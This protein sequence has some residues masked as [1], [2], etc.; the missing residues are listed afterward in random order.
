MGLDS[1]RG[2]TV[3]YPKCSTHTKPGRADLV[4]ETDDTVIGI[5]NK[6]FAPFQ[7]HQPECYL[8]HLKNTAESLAEL[9]GKEFT[10]ALI[11]LAP[12]QRKN[13]IIQHIEAKKLEDKVGF[14]SWQTLLDG[15]DS[16]SGTSTVD[17]FLIRELRDFVDEQIGNV[18]DLP[19]LLPH[20]QRQWAPR[21]TSWQRHFL[22]SFIWS[23]VH[24]FVKE[25][26]GRYRPGIANGYYGWDFYPSK[27]DTATE[28]WFGFMAHEA[29]NQK[30]ALVIATNPARAL[31]KFIE[32]DAAIDVMEDKPGW[33]DS[34]QNWGCYE[35]R[36]SNSSSWNNPQKW[37]EALRPLNNLIESLKG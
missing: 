7:E 2:Q 36:F 5:E 27:G 23:F 35:L 24:D 1:N 30:A 6:F 25:S 32:N 29:E 14:I 9:R 20:L 22:N 31:A 8:P 21:G 15:F 33:T 26:S 12:G 19:R 18:Q 10:W 17:R 4:I 13:E 16:L 34:G 28:I 3:A 37:S 11:I